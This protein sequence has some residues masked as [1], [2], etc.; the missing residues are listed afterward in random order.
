MEGASFADRSHSPCALC[1][2]WEN[3]KSRTTIT[4]K[5]WQ[6]F[7]NGISESFE[8]STPYLIP[9]IYDENILI[10]SSIKIWP[11]IVPLKIL[12]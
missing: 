7:N 4:F 9:I 2:I 3:G 6:N 11:F 1:R 5:I 8:K 12:N 10:Y